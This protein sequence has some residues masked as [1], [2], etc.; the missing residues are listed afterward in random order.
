MG[1]N[2]TAMRKKAQ[3]K[4]EVEVKWDTEREAL[5]NV[6]WEHSDLNDA[7]KESK[8]FRKPIETVLQ[9]FA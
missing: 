8:I 4:A 3:L 1:K 6:D 7:F 2:L 9:R 5:K